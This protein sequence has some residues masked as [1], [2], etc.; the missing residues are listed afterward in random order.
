MSTTVRL[1]RPDGTGA[2]IEGG[3][4]P[5]GLVESM[6]SKKPVT[7]WGTFGGKTEQA[8][9][10]VIAIELGQ[11]DGTLKLTLRCA[12]AGLG[13]KVGQMAWINEYDQ[14]FTGQLS[15]GM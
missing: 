8:N 14:D 2:A 12:E 3:K 11:K 5:G 1:I 10:K 7:F 6:L 13:G 9:F 15:W 4:T